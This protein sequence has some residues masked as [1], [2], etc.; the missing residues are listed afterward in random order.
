ML[1]SRILNTFSNPYAGGATNIA[2]APSGR[3]WVTNDASQLYYLSSSGIWTFVDTNCV[4]VSIGTDGVVWVLGLP[5]TSTTDGN[6]N[7]YRYKG[8]GKGWY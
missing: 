6:H 4:D 7:I 3:P 8:P 5:D 2:V 1:Y